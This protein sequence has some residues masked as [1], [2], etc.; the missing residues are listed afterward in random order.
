MILSS[1]SPWAVRLADLRPDDEG[2]PNDWPG[3]NLALN[4]ARLAR[5]LAEFADDGDVRDFLLLDALRIAVGA[6]LS[7]TGILDESALALRPFRLWEY[8]WLYKGLCLASGG[9]DVLDLGGPASH[10]TILAALAGNRVVSADINPAIVEAGRQC[11]RL[12]SLRTLDA[13]VDDMRELPDLQP[14]SFDVIMSC[15]VL[16]HLTAA[17]QERAL[18]RMAKL[19]RPGGRIGLTFDYGIPAPA[20]NEHLPPPHEPPRSASEALR[21][22]AVTGLSPLGNQLS[23]DPVA[24]TLFR[25]DTVQY[26]MGSLFLGKP[27][28]PSL[29]APQAEMRKPSAFSLLAVD[30]FPLQFYTQAVE[31]HQRRVTA[32]EQEAGLRKNLKIF[33]DAAAERLAELNKKDEALRELQAHATRRSEIEAALTERIEV[34]QSTVRELS[35]NNAELTGKIELIENE[36][37]SAALKRWYGRGP[38]HRTHAQ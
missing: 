28:W 31:A 18:Q 22:Y 1:S 8:A 12:F 21:R 19:L 26:V 35:R 10:L 4:R 38:G 16:E 14:E 34:L 17:D 36:S 6:P 20:A 32:T 3:V 37:L 5:F 29:S 9:Q 33:E 15:S 11:A 23:E 7:S 30:D 24:G 2:L 25:D 27:P 13:R